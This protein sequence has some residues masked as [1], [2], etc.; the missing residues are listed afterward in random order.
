[1]RDNLM[2]LKKCLILP[3]KPWR[4]RGGKRNRLGNKVEHNL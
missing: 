2:H 3:G 4:W 1:V